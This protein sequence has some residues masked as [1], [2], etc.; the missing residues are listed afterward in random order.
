MKNLAILIY[1]VKDIIELNENHHFSTLQHHLL[2]PRR[3]LVKIEI[4]L[5][6]SSFMRLKS[7]L[8]ALLKMHHATNFKDVI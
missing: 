7:Y 2:M 4:L 8:K 5:D 6:M 3:F 1:L